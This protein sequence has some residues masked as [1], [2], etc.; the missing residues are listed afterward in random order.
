[1]LSLL[2]KK[3]KA[4]AKAMIGWREWCALPELGLPAIRAKTD[5]GA[6]TSALHAYDIEYFKKGSKNYVRFKVHP[7]DKNSKLVRK[8]KAPL[9][10]KRTVISSNGKKEIRPVIQTELKI[11]ENVFVT[12]LTLTSRHTMNFRMLLG[13]KAMRAGHF[14]VNPGRSFLMGKL[15][16]PQKL[17]KKKK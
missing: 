14:T 13:R 17:Y 3:K 8:C 10:G 9:I 1:M 7:L 2:K 11:G 6:R 5:T 16:N 15:T 12:E 4:P